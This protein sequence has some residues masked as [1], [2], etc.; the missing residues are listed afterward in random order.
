MSVAAIS[1]KGQITLPIAARRALGL[2]VHDRVMVVV[3]GDKIIIQPVR[4]FFELKGFL[5]KALPRQKE[6]DLMRRA[7]SLHTLRKG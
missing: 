6:R 5:G 2:E 7:A 3:S 1:S 4:D